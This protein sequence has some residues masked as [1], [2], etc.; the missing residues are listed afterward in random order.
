MDAQR[1]DPEDDVT[2]VG[3]HE[4][5]VELRRIAR[6]RS[7]TPSGHALRAPLPPTPLP[8]P[9]PSTPPTSRRA[10]T[11]QAARTPARTSSGGRAAPPAPAAGT[12]IVEWD[13]ED[14]TEGAGLPWLVL[15]A[16]AAVAVAV[17]L[18]LLR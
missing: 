8:P 2:V 14:A 3:D 11:R 15:I 7:T 6:E 10:P 17:T 4:L 13:D 18:I 12:T 1:F 5:V 16:F 9:P